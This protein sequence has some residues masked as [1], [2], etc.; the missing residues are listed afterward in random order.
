MVLLYTY[1]ISSRRV[2]SVIVDEIRGR[3]AYLRSGNH[4]LLSN[5]EEAQLLRYYVTLEVERR[6]HKLEH[7][8]L[9]KGRTETAYGSSLA[10]YDKLI[11]LMQV[12]I[13]SL[14]RQIEF[15]RSAV[16]G[17]CTP[18]TSYYEDLLDQ[19]LARRERLQK[20][21]ALFG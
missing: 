15:Y 12:Q 11:E 2:T 18:S 17:H 4:K 9:Q 20:D 16:S 13:G 3:I 7:K 19:A 6:A 10:Y 14:D 5:D 8:L 1:T 21:L